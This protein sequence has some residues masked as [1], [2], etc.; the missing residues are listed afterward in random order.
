[1]NSG[2]LSWNNFANICILLNAGEQSSKKSYW[3]QVNCENQRVV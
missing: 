2:A 3:R 1:M